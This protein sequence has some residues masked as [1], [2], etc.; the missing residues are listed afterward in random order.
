M[1]SGLSIFE[2]KFIMMKLI[3]YA[4]FALLAGVVFTACKYEEGPGISLRSKRDRIANEWRVE[5]FVYDG[6]DVTSTINDTFFTTIINLYRTGYYGLVIMD[7]FGNTSHTGNWRELHSGIYNRYQGARPRPLN[8]MNNNGKWSFD[9]RHDKIQIYPELSTGADTFN[10]RGAMNWG[11]IQ[12]KEKQLKVIG[13]DRGSVD[14]SMDLKP[15]NGE[16]Y[17]F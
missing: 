17:W 6:Q 5:K 8:D 10:V 16:P 12:L 11:I 1:Y 9:Y 14:W 13:K 3:R 7:K 2:P 15:V 4:S